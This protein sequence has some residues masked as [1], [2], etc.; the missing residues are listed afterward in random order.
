[1]RSGRLRAQLENQDLLMLDQLREAADISTIIE[2]EPGLR[3]WPADRRRSYRLGSAGPG[4]S[5]TEALMTTPCDDR[6]TSTSRPLDTNSCW[7]ACKARDHMT[8]ST[9]TPCGRSRTTAAAGDLGEDGL[10]VAVPAARRGRCGWWSCSKTNGW[11][12]RR[13]ARRWTS[14]FHAQTRPAD[15]LSRG[16]PGSVTPLVWSDTDQRCRWCC[17]SG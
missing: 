5:L 17:R 9:T 2:L 11:T 8:P 6:K 10:Q 1:M 13:W 16:D 7:P 14:S 3:F 4:N 15:G 12:S